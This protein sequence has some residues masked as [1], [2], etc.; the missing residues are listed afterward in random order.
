MFV[1]CRFRLFSLQ[2]VTM[3]SLHDVLRVHV[4]A[5]SLLTK[6][7]QDVFLSTCMK[8]AGSA[9]L[10][11]HW[12]QGSGRHEYGIHKRAAFLVAVVL[13]EAQMLGSNKLPGDGYSMKTLDKALNFI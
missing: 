10:D 13:R 2:I 8:F 6:S 4:A 3:T 11:W 12:C 9:H 1:S 7:Q 5:L